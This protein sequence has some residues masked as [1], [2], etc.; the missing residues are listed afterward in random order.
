MAGKKRT[1]DVVDGGDEELLPK[2][3]KATKKSRKGADKAEDG[4]KVD[5]D[6]G[7]G[8]KNDLAEKN[9]VGAKRTRV[10]P[11]IDMVRVFDSA[12]AYAE[13]IRNKPSSR[14]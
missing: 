13:I 11:Q 14:C 6:K 10:A 12:K 8:R 7:D 5:A 4:D 3:A 1:A 2:T 9:E